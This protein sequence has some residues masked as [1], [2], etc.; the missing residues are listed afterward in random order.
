MKDV[1]EGE[2]REVRISER[3]VKLPAAVVSD[4]DAFTANKMR[5]EYAGVMRQTSS[6]QPPIMEINPHNAMIQELL[7]RV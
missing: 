1:L 2:V 6:T 5:L 7:E 3:L 4:K